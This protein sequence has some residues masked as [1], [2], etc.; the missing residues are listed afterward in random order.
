MSSDSSRSGSLFGSAFAVVGLP[1][2]LLAAA[3]MALVSGVGPIHQAF[4]PL[5]SLTAAEAAA[6]GDI[7]ALLAA[8]RAGSSL[9]APQPVRAGIIRR[10]RSVTPLEAAVLG[11]S[12]RA[13]TFLLDA[14][15]EPTTADIRRLLCFAGDSDRRELREVLIARFGP[16]PPGDCSAVTW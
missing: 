13:L 6:Q 15:V 2:M 11:K 5:P 8:V 12:R 14:G 3:L 16:Q 7:P 10:A 4:W 9:R 1:P